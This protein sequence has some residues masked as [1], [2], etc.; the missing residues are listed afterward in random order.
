MSEPIK[1]ENLNNDF[2]DEVIEETDEILQARAK[3][4]EKYCNMTREEIFALVQSEEEKEMEEDEREAQKW[5][6]L[7]DSIASVLPAIDATTNMPPE[8]IKI[9][10]KWQL[11]YRITWYPYE[12]DG[13]DIVKAYY[14]CHLGVIIGSAKF[15]VD[16]L[17]RLDF[18]NDEA[19]DFLS[20][21]E[22]FIERDL[23]WNPAT[24]LKYLQDEEYFGSEEYINSMNA[25]FQSFIADLIQE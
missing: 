18:T 9:P 25:E 15:S 23:E 6:L 13:E 24:T 3:I 14:T 21:M 19:E 22:M 10:L 5:I 12:Y 4:K 7:P 8:D 20:A 17:S 2:D 1:D 16:H 11:G